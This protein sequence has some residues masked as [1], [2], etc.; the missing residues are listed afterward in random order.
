MLPKIDVPIYE[1]KLISSG[2]T[3]RYRP[4][5]VKEQKLFLMAAESEDV[6]DTI[7]AI[8]QVINNCVLD[9][10]DVDNLSTFD[11]EYL[12]IQLRARSINEVVNLAFNCNNKIK[13]EKDEEKICGNLVKYDLNLLEI[14]P[15]K[16]DKHTDKIQLTDKLGVVLKY[17]TFSA[18]NKLDVNS[19]DMEQILDVIINCIDYIYDDEQVYYAKDST[20]KEL[21]EFVE[22]MKQTDLEKVQDFFNTLP[23]IKKDLHF[24]CDKCGYEEDIIVEGIQNFFV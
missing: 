3:I 23:K 7:S 5:L 9:D 13:N 19:D 15:T 2:K 20:K 21:L 22:N 4:F 11:I 24:K 14:E 8:K 12:F 1:T 18:V 10:I 6:K 17:P 16:N